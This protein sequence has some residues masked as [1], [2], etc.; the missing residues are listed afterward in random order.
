MWC[1]PTITK[2]FVVRMENLLDLYTEAPN[3]DEPLLCMD[4]KSKQL[5]K[6]TRTPIP[7]K[8]GRPKRADYEY[9]RN[10]TR[11]I[12]LAVAP[13]EGGRFLSVRKRRTKQDFA[14]FIKYLLNER[15]ADAKKIHLV[16]DNLNTHFPFS[17][18]AAFPKA[19]AERLLQRIQFHYTPKHASWLN[20]AEIELSILSNQ[21]VKGRIG[22]AQ[23]LEK[24]IRAWEEARNAAKATIRWKFT[25]AD[26]RKKFSYGTE[27][28]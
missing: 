19:E 1:I 9:E 18:F 23:R 22:T 17:F 12:F 26:A 8:P 5:L 3:P 4:E 28:V 21:C 16:W 27:L 25:V 10:G 13:H 7:M 20:L 2:E 14:E 6:E 24:N 15:Y 11:N